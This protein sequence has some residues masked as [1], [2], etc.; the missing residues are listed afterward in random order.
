MVTLEV[1]ATVKEKFSMIC[2]GV[3]LETKKVR[4]SFS[5]SEYI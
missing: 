1:N 2:S 5:V 3:I 4:N